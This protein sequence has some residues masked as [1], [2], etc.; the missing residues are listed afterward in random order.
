VGSFDSSLE[1]S[2]AG[3]CLATPPIVMALV[4]TMASFDHV[5]VAVASGGDHVVVG[6]AKFMVTTRADKE[7][8]ADIGLVDGKPTDHDVVPRGKVV[9]RVAM[10]TVVVEG[11]AAG[12]AAGAA[13]AVAAVVADKDVDNDVDVVVVAKGDAIAVDV[14]AR[15]HAV[16]V[17]VDVDGVV[18]VVVAVAVEVDVDVAVAVAVVVVAA[19]G[20][21]AGDSSM[22][23]LQ[24]TG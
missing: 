9:T 23:V 14:S 5:G 8:N 4:V 15:G 13:V 17:D 21:A 10:A 1:E 16:C 12:V 24:R 7:G 2:S 19:V 6:C 20:D 18:A 11:G 22:V 3:A